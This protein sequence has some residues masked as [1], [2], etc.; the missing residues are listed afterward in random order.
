MGDRNSME[1]SSKGAGKGLS[2]RVLIEESPL[3]SS[4]VQ[5]CSIFLVPTKGIFKN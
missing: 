4:R 2:E 3:L 1:K 5:V